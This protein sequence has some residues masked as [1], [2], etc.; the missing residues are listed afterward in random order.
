[1]ASRNHFVNTCIT[2][3]QYE[4]YHIII[5][6]YIYKNVSYFNQLYKS[7]FFSLISIWIIVDFQNTLSTNISGEAMC[8]TMLLFLLYMFPDY[9][10]VQSYNTIRCLGSSSD[11]VYTNKKLG[12][13]CLTPLSIIFQLYCGS[14]FYLWRKPKYQV[15][16]TDLPQV[17]D[18]LSHIAMSRIRNYDVS[19]DRHWLHR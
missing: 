1:M 6:I 14:Q 11:V 4:S 18:N 16:T 3:D 12:L 7:D 17:T 13:C 2:L 19:G 9:W 10:S 8:K 15:K 5:H